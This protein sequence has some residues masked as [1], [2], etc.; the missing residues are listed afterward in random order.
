MLISPDEIKKS[1]LNKGCTYK[2]KKILKIFKFNSYMEGVVFANNI[3]K[4]A[5]THNHHP[6]IKISWCKLEIEI[7]SHEKN[8]VTTKCINLATKIDLI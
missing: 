2:D 7:S 8:G 4:L 1:L 5:E 6:I 3:A